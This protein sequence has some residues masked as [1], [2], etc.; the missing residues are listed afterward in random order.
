M[1]FEKIESSADFQLLCKTM[2]EL[3]N[4]EDCAHFLEDLCSIAEIV[5]MSK[6]MRAA[7]MLF[8][9][10]TDL[11]QI[12]GHGFLHFFR[13]FEQE[14]GVTLNLIHALAQRA[15]VAQTVRNAEHLRFGAGE[16]L[17]AGLLDFPGI[18]PLGN[19]SVHFVHVHFVAARILAHADG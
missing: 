17:I 16:G 5:D 4:T 19:V 11:I 12:A 3:K 6:R 7:E 8:H 13:R 9:I 1:G 14:A 2:L 15:F 18:Q 10:R